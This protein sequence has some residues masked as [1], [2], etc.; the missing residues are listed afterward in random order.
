MRRF[1]GAALASLGAALVVCLAA[2][3]A[4]AEPV[5]GILR[6]DAVGVSESAEQ[7]FEDNI[8]EGLS[9][10]GFRVMDRAS[11][12]KVMA[13]STSFVEGCSFG[14]C[15]RSVHD[16]TGLDTVL[17]ARIEG[18]GR[19]YSFVV[20]LVDTKSGRYVSQVAQNCPVCTV[21]DAITTATLSAVEL[22]LGVETVKGKPVAVRPP[23]E[24][25]LLRRGQK[26][27]RIGWIGV[28]VGAGAALGGLLVDDA[29]ARAAL[30]SGGAV[31]AGAGGF[32]VIYG[33]RF[34]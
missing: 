32:L 8:H 2:P 17:V 4:R 24:L 9:G 31:M 34:R 29:A 26:L 6:I 28:A 21:E 16:A 12:Q 25:A 33:G 7:K 3:A 20:T 30:V 5:I 23:Y 19:A 11:L 1:G 14:P 22:V 27:R 13:T 15:L 18:I 10:A